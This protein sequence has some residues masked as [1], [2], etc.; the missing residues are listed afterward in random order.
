MPSVTETGAHSDSDRPRAGYS[1][2]VGIDLGASARSTDASSAIAVLDSAGEL[3]GPPRHFRRRVELVELV[4]RL[5]CERTLIAVDAPR[6]VPDHREE[7]YARRSCETQL[8]AASKGH[9]GSFYGAAALF[10]RWH[11]I[12]RAH[13]EG[14][15]LIEVYPRTIW[16]RLGLPGTPKDRK[17][18]MPAVLK[19]M[20]T[21]TGIDCVGFSAHQFDATLAAFT[22]LCYA[23]GQVEL[24]GNEGEGRLVVPD[25]TK[26]VGTPLPIEP[27]AE[28][29]RRFPSQAII[30]AG[31]P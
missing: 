5:P 14:W 7:D 23:R 27:I 4:H 22:A 16:H 10:V 1:F 24:Y 13:F 6:S 17:A 12:E 2:H 19:K 29:F 28:P 31:E 20:Q 11:E 21:I 8:Q 30:P 15:R 9:V 26:P 3:V 18:N 25:L